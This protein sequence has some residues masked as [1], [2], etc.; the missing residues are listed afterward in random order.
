M[1]LPSWIMTRWRG[2]FGTPRGRLVSRMPISRPD[3]L[4]ADMMLLDVNEAAPDEEDVAAVAA[5][6]AQGAG[7]SISPVVRVQIERPQR[8]STVSSSLTLTVRDL[9]RLDGLNAALERVGAQR[10]GTP[11]YAVSDTSAGRR[12]ARTK[13]LAQA[14]ADGEAY[15]AALNMRIVRIAR[16]SERGGMDMM[17]LMFSEMAGAGGLGRGPIQASAGEVPSYVFLGIDYVLAPR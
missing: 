14:R 17:G 1:K 12:T 13:A 8:P 3:P 11:Q 10:N 16:I 6:T 2:G 9:S 4:R 15:A 5:P 7:T